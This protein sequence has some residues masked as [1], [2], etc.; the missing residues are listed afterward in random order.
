MTHPLREMGVLKLGIVT[1]TVPLFAVS[2]ATG[3]TAP[4]GTL[5]IFA[6]LAWYLWYDTT[7]TK[8]A[9]RQEAT[10]LT[11]QFLKQLEDE[12]ALYRQFL[13]RIIKEES[14]VDEAS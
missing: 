11:T 14:D 3:G 1:I 9:M 10:D 6:I 8:P 13:E 4:W 5:G 7:I 2:D 12:R